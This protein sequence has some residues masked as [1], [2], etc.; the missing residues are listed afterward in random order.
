MRDL[1]IETPEGI[2]FSW[3]LAGPVARFLAWSIDA[4]VLATGAYVIQQLASVAGVV[5]ADAAAAVWTVLVF[6]LQ[7]GYAI[8]LEWWWRGQTIGKRV[9][10]IRVLDAHGLR[11]HASQIVVRNLL[12]VVDSLPA[13]YV[14]G[15]LSCLFTRHAQRLGDIAA[16][17]VVVRHDT[18]TDRAVSVDTRLKYN[19]LRAHAHL[20]ARLR[21]RSTPEEAAVALRAL[22]RRNELEP[23]ARAA[24]FDELAAHFRGKVEFPP[25]ALDGLGSEQYVRD[26]VDILYD[27]TRRPKTDTSARTA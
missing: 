8:A 10:R 18:A 9:L 26:V 5:S 6:V 11:L 23:A 20:A 24:L 17:T 13:L 2:T 4:A 7:T 19:S 21:Q 1:R 25:E 12:R 14:V 3:P 16:G 15:V 22:H 27:V